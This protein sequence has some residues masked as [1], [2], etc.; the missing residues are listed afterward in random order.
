MK[1]TEESDGWRLTLDQGFVQLI[2]IDFRLGLFLSDGSDV[3]KLYVESECL[4]RTPGGEDRMNPEDPRSLVA[5]LPFAQGAKVAHISIRKTGQLQL[6]FESGSS[7]EVN[8]QQRFEA[9]QLG[10]SS[11]GLLMVCAPGGSVALFEKRPST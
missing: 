8:P 2:Q 4:L 9:W 10:S 3:A 1:L 5:I 7:L 11:I 6:E